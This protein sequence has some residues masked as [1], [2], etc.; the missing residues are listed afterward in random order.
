MKKLI[1]LIGSIFLLTG[2][3]DNIELNDLAIVSGLGI[4]YYNE[5]FHIT[6]EI[7]N[8]IKTE[9]NSAMLSYTVEGDGKTLSEAFAN[10]NYRVGKNA[11][12]AHLKIVLLSES[13]IK[14]K[15]PN[16]IDYLIRDTNIRD[17]FIPLV[18]ENVKPEEILSH[19]SKD[20]PVVSDFLLN[21]IDNEKYNNNLATNEVYQKVL[22]KFISDNYDVVLSSITLKDE[23]IS[24]SHFYI[25]NGYK[26]RNKLSIEE[27]SL[28]NLLTTNVYNVLFKN[29][30]DNKN[31]SI[32]INNAIQE[33][34][35]SKDKIKIDLKLEGKII[36][37]NANLDLKKEKTYQ[38]LDEDF[39]QI[40]A[41]KVKDF[42]GNLQKNESDIM[43]LQDIYYKKWRKQNKGL[44][45][46]ADILVNVDLKINTKGFIFE[47]EQ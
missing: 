46:S 41:K 27:S 15:I 9:E 47:V 22:V 43:G 40:I 36:E 24:L 39:G 42:V 37:N 7:L 13:I 11:Y 30:Y 1:I 25:F 6:Y 16:I 19:N 44:W 23:E 21:L 2:C 10:A 3:Y 5:N 18:T 29:E 12:F 8:D 20:C 17:E 26:V 34:D 45:K 38:M 14:D 31:I 4:D 33:I 28:Y 32:S 35:V